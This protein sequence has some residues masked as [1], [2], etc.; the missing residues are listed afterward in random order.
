M[1]PKA[2]S[3]ALWDLLS[4]LN[5]IPEISSCY[6][7]GET[8]LALQLEH[9]VS[10]DLDFLTVEGFDD[11]S[12]QMAI[13]SKGLDTVVLNQTTSHTELMMG[14]A[15]IDLIRERIP[16]NFPL[17]P[18]DKEIANLSMAD[19][20]DIGRMKIMA[21]GSRGS[22]K[23]FVDIYCLTRK[24]LSLETLLSHAMKEDGGIRYS[25]LL[26]LKGLVDF[27]EAD[28]EVDLQLLWDVSWEEVKQCLT[29]EVKEIAEK[30]Q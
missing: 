30:I 9:R 28:R 27:D 4:T 20:R 29:I 15:K 8:A 13:K 7:G 10:E 6:L 12:F 19:A 2:I 22:K 17:K 3:D 5:A 14:A 25:K 23:D 16:L 21:I 18:I 24:V 1:R 26:F 11:F